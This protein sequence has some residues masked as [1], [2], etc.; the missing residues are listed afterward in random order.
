MNREASI[1][2]AAQLASETLSQNAPGFC[3][4]SMQW[5]RFFVS[6]ETVQWLHSD[7]NNNNNS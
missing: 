5:S 7:S 2:A 6:L 1:I 4:K 3:R